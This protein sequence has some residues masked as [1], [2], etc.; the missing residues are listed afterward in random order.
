VSKVNFFADTSGAPPL[1]GP[2]M[3]ECCECGQ[4]APWGDGQ[5]FYCAKHAPDH[6]KRPYLYVT[7]G[8]PDADGNE[9]P[10]P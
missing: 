8:Q 2:L 4:E 7:E 1:P 5:D 6:L 9:H 3:E 10:T